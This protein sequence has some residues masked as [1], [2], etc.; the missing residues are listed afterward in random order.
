MEIITIL[1]ALIVMHALLD[2]PLQGDAVAVNKNPNANTPLQK[3]VPCY[4]WLLSHALVHGGG[5][6][7]I[8]GSVWL[9]MA[10]TLA[11][12]VIDY[13]KCMGR[14]SIHI[15]QLLH[16]ICKI[17]WVLVFVLWL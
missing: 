11:H 12:F 10:E 16:V 7:L 2:F 13:N 15:D 4:Y 14:Y 1:F 6:M 17:I 5:V 3:H 9:G 8:T